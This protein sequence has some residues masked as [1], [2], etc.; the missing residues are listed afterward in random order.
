MNRNFPCKKCG[1]GADKHYVSVA[2]EDFP[3][4]YVCLTCAE[5]GR[6]SWVEVNEHLHQFV[7]DNLKYMELKNKKKEILNEQ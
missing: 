5:G 4:K 7:G 2:D 6:S 1:H 3:L